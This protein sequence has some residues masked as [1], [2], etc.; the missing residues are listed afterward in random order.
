MNDR[1]TILL[2]QKQ[3][4]LDFCPSTVRAFLS[5]IG[6]KGG[7]NSKRKLTTADAQAMTVRSHEARRRNKEAR[8][9]Q[10]DATGHS[11]AS[12]GQSEEETKA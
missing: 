3:K 2:K 7:K 8:E 6:R 5:A 9:Q 11:G 12:L 1:D 10:N 4:D